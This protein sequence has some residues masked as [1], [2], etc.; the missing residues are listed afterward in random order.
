MAWS[1]RMR[2]SIRIECY[3]AARGCPV[4]LPGVAAGDPRSGAEPRLLLRGPRLAIV[5]SAGVRHNVST[6]ILTEPPAVRTYSTFP[7]AIQ[8]VMVRR[9]TPTSSNAFLIE[10][11]CLSVIA[12]SYVLRG[13]GSGG[14][15]PATH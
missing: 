6:K 11:V 9:L 4:P 5:G 1:R 10:T 2:T 13:T 14:L 15:V 3:A 12:S 8:L 7:L